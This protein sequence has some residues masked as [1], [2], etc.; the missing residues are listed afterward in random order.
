MGSLLVSLCV[1]KFLIVQEFLHAHESSLR[2]QSSSQEVQARAGNHR[3]RIFLIV[4]G[5][6]D[7]EKN[8]SDP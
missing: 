6:K 1:L 7:G 3:K 2:Q 8:I 5:I 4:H